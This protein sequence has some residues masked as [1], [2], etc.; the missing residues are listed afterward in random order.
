MS[1]ISMNTL[2]QTLEAQVGKDALAAAFVAY[3]GAQPAVAV[4]Q[5]APAVAAIAAGAPSPVLDAKAK[6]KAAREAAAARKAAAAAPAAAAVAA[7]AAA[8]AAPAPAD[9]SDG[10]DSTASSQKRRGPKKLSD[11]T[12]EER[13]AHDAKISKRKAEKAAGQPLPASPPLA[14][15]DP[16]VFA[17]FTHAG[18]KYLRNMRGDLVE[19]VTFDWVGRFDSKTKTIDTK[20]PQPAD[21]ADE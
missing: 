17:E 21:L 1:S 5:V 9:A 7:P 4:K 16:T 2:F 14:T 10:G 19:P 15:E 13:A 11:M 18:V 8:A 20:F 6:M 12:A 3:S